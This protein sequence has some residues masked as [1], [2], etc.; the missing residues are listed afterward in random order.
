MDAPVC[1]PNIGPQQRRMRRKL[2]FWALGI[3]AAATALLLWGD[4]TRLWRLVLAPL[5]LGGLFGIL[6]ARGST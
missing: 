4:A 1:I 2:G 6:Q 5:V 3:A